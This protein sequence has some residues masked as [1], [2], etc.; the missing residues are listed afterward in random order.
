MSFSLLSNTKIT[1]WILNYPGW[2]FLPFKKYNCLF[3]LHVCCQNNNLMCDRGIL[4]LQI[5]C[6]KIMGL[7]EHKTELLPIPSYIWNL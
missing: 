1:E 4:L 3:I 6:L 2:F 5:D 7:L